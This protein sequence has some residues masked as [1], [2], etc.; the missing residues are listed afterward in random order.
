M[1]TSSRYPPLS[2]LTLNVTLSIYFSIG[3]D[4]RKLDDGDE[5][6]G[7]VMDEFEGDFELT[8]NMGH[9]KESL[10]SSLG[11]RKVSFAAS[12]DDGPSGRRK[13]SIQ[14]TEVT[15]RGVAP[16]NRAQSNPATLAAMGFSGARYGPGEVPRPDFGNGLGATIE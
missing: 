7:L 5:M 6:N 16:R 15:P 12:S 13:L 2:R 11:H 1:I 8:V 3:K 14:N 9:R 4:G 10:S